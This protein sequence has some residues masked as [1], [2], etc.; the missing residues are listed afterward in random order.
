MHIR[1]V[2]HGPVDVYGGG[3]VLEFDAEVEWRNSRYWWRCV[4]WMEMKAGLVCAGA[5]VVPDCTNLLPWVDS[6]TQ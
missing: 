4:N 3:S 1:S 6:T 2:A 5:T